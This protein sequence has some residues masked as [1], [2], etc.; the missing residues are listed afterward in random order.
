MLR[1]LSTAACGGLAM[2]F[3][4]CADGTAES[5]ERPAWFRSKRGT[6][7]NGGRD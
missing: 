4:G 1:L 5:W 6:N 2:A 7:G 3:A